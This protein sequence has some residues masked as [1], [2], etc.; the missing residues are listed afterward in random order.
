MERV[1][2]AAMERRCARRGTGKAR[3]RA[4]LAALPTV[5]L[6]ACAGS[7]ARSDLNRTTAPTHATTTVAALPVLRREDTLW[8]ERVTFGLDSASV[9]E[10]RRLGRE[11]FLERPL[12]AGDAS[13]P[14]PI[15][16]QLAALEGAQDDPARW[17]AGVHNGY[18]E[19]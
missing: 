12:V 16:P 4:V 11:R 8:L 17:Q 14:T 10:Y 3:L 5:L 15:D 6:L 7:G 2:G 1:L 19:F 18:Q 9:A 13:L